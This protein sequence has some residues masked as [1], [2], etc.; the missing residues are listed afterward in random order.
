[1][2]SFVC[3]RGL[4]PALSRVD[5]DFPNYLTAAKVVVDQRSADRLY[6]QSWFRE[7]ARSYGFENS[8][9]TSFHPFPPP[10]ALILVPVARLQPL[11]A[12]RVMTAVNMACL[13]AAVVLLARILGWRVLDSAIFVLL[14]GWAIIACL[15]FGQL[16]IL[17]STLSILGYYAYI[18]GSPRLA[19]VCFGLFTPIK[20]YPLIYPAYF[21][22]RRQWKVALG[23]AGAVLAVALI[24]L[25]VLGWKI[26]EVYILSV[27]GNHLVARIGEQDPF[28]AYFQSFDTLFRRLFVLD[29]VLNPHPLW[30][31]PLAQILC[32]LITKVGIALLG[33]AA[34]IRLARAEKEMATGPSIGILAI[35]LMLLAPGTATYHFAT[36][37]LPVGLLI[38]YFLRQGVQPAAYFLLG[39]YALIGFFPYKYTYPFEGR[40]G[41]T[42]LAYPRLFSVAAMFI[43]CAYFILRR[44]PRLQPAHCEA[45]R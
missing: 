31:A 45:S 12:L 3:W 32:T 14:S 19:G 11:S 21:A 41:L 7:Q 35:L 18:R 2:V 17:V 33:A 40:G 23:A 22:A 43:V 5:T 9:W 10:T 39:A 4:V 29:P 42:V 15:R 38:N 6:D 30:V 8:Q 20:Y 24:S 28:T 13:V 26:H 36:L 25:A 44:A 1:L 27:L 34:L 16:Y 37:W